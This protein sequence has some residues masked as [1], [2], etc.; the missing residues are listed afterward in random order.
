MSEYQYHEW[1]AL[2]RVL[3]PEEQAAVNDLSSHIEV[4]SS[5]A[6]VT[7]HWSDFRHDPKQV[8]LKYFDAYFY[9]A[10][11]GSLRL[12][13]RFPKG[14]LDEV[15]I[16]P[17]YL[18]ECITFETIGRYQVLDLDFNPE[19]GGGWMEAEAVLSHFIRLRA[20][21]LEGDY[22]LL[23]LAWLK[24]MTLYGDPFEEEDEVDD[25]DIAAYDCEPP[26]PPGLKKLSPS[27]QNFVQVFEIDPFLMKAAAEASPDPKKALA[28]DYRELIVHL[29]R[30]E[31]DDFLA[32]LA[33]GDPGVGLALRKRLGAYTPKESPQPTSRRTIQR[34]IQRAGQLEKAEKVRQEEATRQK[35]IAKMKALAGREAQVLQQVETLLDTGRKIASVYDEAT[36]LLEKLNQLAEFQD[37]RDVFRERLYHLAQIYASRPS[38]IDRWKKRGWI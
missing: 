25:T 26:I 37:T 1:Q 32:R 19:D 27:L 5:R 18:D 14:L 30:A 12:M 13:F 4:S 28:I 24:A 29:P 20:D 15:D 38:L 2:D 34:L 31:C 17:Y 36:A 6:V 22:Q 33:E 8:L 21:L 3:T 35:H 9:L 16:L 7:Y 23:Y 10:N 11:W